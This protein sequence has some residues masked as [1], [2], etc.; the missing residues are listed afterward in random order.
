MPDKNYETIL[1]FDPGTAIVGW[2]VLYARGDEVRVGKYGVQETSKHLRDE[3]R[4]LLV[5]QGV[6]EL[7]KQWQPDVMALERQF[8]ARNQT[9]ALKVAQAVGVIL[10]AAVQKGLPVVEYTPPQ[11]KLAVVGEGSADKK[12]V[13]YM[14]TRILNLKETPK[15]DD[16]ADA[17]AI[18]LCHAHSRRLKRMTAG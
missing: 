13:Q 2:A 15:P 17:L 14:V 6:G 4:L 9:T 10:L 16:A 18:A 12:Q 1:A 3:A 8:F 11:V 5:Y 7:M